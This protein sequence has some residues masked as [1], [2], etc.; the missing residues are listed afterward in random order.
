MDDLDNKG[1]NSENGTPFEPPL[2]EQ[3]VDTRNVTDFEQQSG[4]GVQQGNAPQQPYGSGQP[5][6]YNNGYQAPPPPQNGGY[7]PYGNIRQYDQ[8]DN[9]NYQNYNN[10]YQNGYPQNFQPAYNNGY[11]AVRQNP[12]KTSGLAIASFVIALVNLIVFRTVLSVIA[13]P[14]SIILAI[15]SLA[16]KRTGTGFAITGIIISVISMILFCSAILVIVKLYPDMKY[17]IENEH[18]IVEDYNRDGTIP[19][20]FEKYN[21]PRFNKYW[22]AMGCDDFNEFFGMFIE[23]FEKQYN[24]GRYQNDD[25]FAND[26]DDEN[27]DHG[28]TDLVFA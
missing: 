23:S 19:E 27:Y 4:Q 3:G 6:N 8:Y 9:K 7:S 17:F 28:I 21:A 12:A 16:K 5:N 14:L 1:Y 15:V 25:D 24:N 18:Q 10:G 13:V 22:S 11:G 20:Q 2:G 26:Y